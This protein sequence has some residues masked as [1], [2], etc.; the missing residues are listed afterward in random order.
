MTGCACCGKPTG[1]PEEH[2]HNERRGDN[3]PDNL[4]TLDRRH[5]MEHHENERSVDELTEQRFGPR[6][7]SAGPP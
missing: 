4:R 2:H 6:R 3:V 5:H 1:C 7:P